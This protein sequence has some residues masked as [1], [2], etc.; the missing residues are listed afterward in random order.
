MIAAAVVEKVPVFQGPDN[1]AC[2]GK[3]ITVL[4]GNS[5][6]GFPDWLQMLGDSGFVICIKGT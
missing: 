6:Y 5:I 3:I 2:S 1:V 4:G